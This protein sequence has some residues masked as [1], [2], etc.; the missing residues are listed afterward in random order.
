M[1]SLA[2]RLIEELAR[3]PS[4]VCTV[5]TDGAIGELFLGENPRV[6]FRE[7]WATIEF[8]C[9]HIHMDLGRVGRVRFAEEPS[10]CSSVSAYVSIEDAEGR[11]LIRFFFPHAG[12]TRTGP[13]RPRNWRCFPTFAPATP[14]SRRSR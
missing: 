11:P 12:P 8:P 9:W 5:G 14:T 6:G 2:Q 10:Q 7:G 4:L 3:Q 13:T 1:S